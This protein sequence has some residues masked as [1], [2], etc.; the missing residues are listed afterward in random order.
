MN[1]NRFHPWIVCGLLGFVLSAGAI[2]AQDSAAPAAAPPVAMAPEAPAPVATAPTPGAAPVPANAPA[3]APVVKLAVAPKPVIIPFDQQSYQVSVTLGF[4][5]GVGIS[6]SEARKIERQLAGMIES[7]VGKWWQAEIQLAPAS[8]PQSRAML[9]SIS[10][11]QWNERMEAS[12]FDKRFALVIGR[13]GTAYRISGIEWDR[14]SQTTTQIQSRQ[15]YD[16]RI[17]A[18]LAADLTFSLFR[19]LISVETVNEKTVEMR[20]RGGDFLPLDAALM[21][22]SVGEFIS[23]YVRYMGKNRELLRIKHIPWTMVQVD[24]VERGY[25]RGTIVSAFATPLSGQ[26]RRVEMMGM[27]IKPEWPQTRLTVIPRGKPQAPMAGYRVEV[28][29]RQETKEDKVEDRLKLRT[30]RNGEVVIP[31]DPEHPLRYLV[32]YSGIAPLAKAPLIPGHEKEAVLSAPDDAPRLN[33]EAETELLQSELVDIVAKREVLMARTRAAA[34]KANWEQVTEL[35][36]EISGLPNLAQFEA[37][38]E[39]LQLPAIQ[40][41]KRNKDKGQESRINRMCKQITDLA[42]THL[43]PTKIKEFLVE[44]EEEKKSQ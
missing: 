10:Q 19:P 24:R 41:A 32:V 21:P 42:T 28:L 36:K 23:P 7:R 3:P 30:D 8:E 25:M 35:S 34:K 39:A 31:T 18:G 13:L 5:S 1:P 2:I 4:A 20:I 44:M 6:D 14:S 38:I 12:P 16:H 22:Y 9:E 26:R 33:V 27:K 15:T 40:V 37:R 43:D 11:K 17:L 29:N